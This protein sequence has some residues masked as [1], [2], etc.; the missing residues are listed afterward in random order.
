MGRFRTNFDDGLPSIGETNSGEQVTETAGYIPKN[1]QIRQM[2]LAGEHLQEI[3]EELYDFKPGEEVPEGYIDP[4]RSPNFDWADADKL[5]A[6]VRHNARRL[7]EYESQRVSE[8]TVTTDELSE[9][10]DAG[11]GTLGT[12]EEG[13]VVS[14]DGGT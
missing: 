14:K 12:G 13:A 10:N 11:G 8:D 5:L 3:R 7:A 4:T 9:R 2:M 1:L 6:I